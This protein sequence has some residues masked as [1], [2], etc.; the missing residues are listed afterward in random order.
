MNVPRPTLV[1]TR[2][3]SADSMPRAKPGGIENPHLLKWRACHF[4]NRQIVILIMM[5]GA[6]PLERPAKPIRA[7]RRAIPGPGAEL[8]PGCRVIPCTS[9]TCSGCR[10][11]TPRRQWR[12]AAVRSGRP[13]RPR[14]SGCRWLQ[15][16]WHRVA[17]TH[18]QLFRAIMRHATTDCSPMDAGLPHMTS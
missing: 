9:G 15:R 1:Q 8:R 6:V 18:S 16:H 13:R 3:A 11:G 4:P 10:V 2:H 17:C 14:R 12:P 7:A 5:H